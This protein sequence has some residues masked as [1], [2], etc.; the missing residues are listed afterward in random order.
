M[1]APSSSFSCTPAFQRIKQEALEASFNV[2]FYYI[3]LEALE[4]SNQTSL[5]LPYGA[6]KDP[7][8]YFQICL[9]K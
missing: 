8:Q 6:G 2:F 7:A 4:A 9:N 5:S 3:M 1:V